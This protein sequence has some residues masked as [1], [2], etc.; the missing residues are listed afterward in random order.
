M[1]ASTGS[2][3]TLAYSLPVI[4]NLL[5]Q[6]EFGYIRQPQRPRCLVLVPTRELARQVLHEIK[7]VGHF[8]KVSSAAVLGGETYSLQKKSVSAFHTLNFFIKTKFLRLSIVRKISRYCCCITR[9]T[10]A[11]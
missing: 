6:E 9:K 11:T 7:Q 1:A 5:Q 4:Q 2:G 8:A 3:K 10:Y